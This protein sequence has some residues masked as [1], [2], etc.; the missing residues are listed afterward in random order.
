MSQYKSFKDF[1]DEISLMQ[2][3]YELGYR[4]DKSKG[5]KTPSFIL[6]DGHNHEIDRLYIFNPLDNTKA[7]FFRR[8]PGPGR[9]QV[10][11][12]V[13]FIKEN[14]TSFPENA[15]ARNEVDAI[16][17]VCLRLSNTVVDMS[18]MMGEEA[19]RYISR[20]ERPFNL[21]DY[22]RD[23]GN[24]K[25][26]MRFFTER[27][28]DAGTAELF[29]DNFELIRDT[30]AENKI[31]WK[32][33]GFPYRRPGEAEIVGYEVRG[34]GKYKSKS[35][36]TDSS[37][38]C[39]QAYLGKLGAPDRIPAYDIDQIHIAESA[40]DIMSYVQLHQGRLDLD[41]TL[42]V[43]VGGTFTNELMMRLFKEYPTAL[44][45]FHF[46]ND[47]TGVMY[48]IRAAAIK[49][50]KT[51]RS[52]TA[53]GEVRFNLDGKEFSV[54]ADKLSYNQFI[55]ASGLSADAR[56]KIKIE[57]APGDFKDWNE[58]L[59]T[60]M[61]AEKAQKKPYPPEKRRGTPNN[62]D[63]NPEDEQPRLKR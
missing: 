21:E 28:I 52:T 27:G 3:V 33:L 4:I 13:Q 38:A 26:A 5:K 60:A 37:R 49:I 23:K 56:P 22:E 7:N 36:G 46:D 39:W 11:D 9:A 48:D 14:I 6:T 61:A 8:N 50:G 47:I 31:A 2:V 18:K 34:F 10:G 58:V 51:L 20:P 17:K 63:T 25:K 41:R 19:I 57:K 40:Y 55:Q 24:W 53:Q 54:P 44:P 32:N 15:T 35:E 1:R 30:K 59:Q 45:V 42:F 43:S 16:N 29:K 12:V 62:P